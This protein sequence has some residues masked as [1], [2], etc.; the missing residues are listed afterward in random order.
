MNNFYYRNPTKII[1]G[2]GM[3][4][5]IANEIPKDAKVLILYGS[6]SIK[7]NGV[8]EQVTIALNEFEVV[9]FGGI[10]ANPTYEKCMDALD[11][12]HKEE[13]TYLLAV[14]GGSVIDAAKFLALSFYVKTSDKP[15][16][17]MRDNSKAPTEALPLG[18]ILTLSAT[19]SEMNNGFVISRE[20]TKEKLTCGSFYIY[21]QFSVL[22][23]ET[24]YFL[25]K[26][27]LRN[28]LVDIFIHVVEQYVTTDNNTPLQD[29]QAEA[30]LS[31]VLEISDDVMS[32]QNDYNSRAS[33]MW[34]ATQAL[35]GLIN[36]GVIMDWSTHDIGHKLTAQYGLAHAETIGIILRGVWENQ[37]QNKLGKLAQFGERV[38]GFTGSEEERAQ[39]AIEA[40]ENF[41]NKIGMD[42]HFSNYDIDGEAAAELIASLYMN[43]DTTNLGESSELSSNVIRSIVASRK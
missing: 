18:A 4:A 1:F 42:T 8:Y 39:K 35:N 37:F 34:C 29:R 7:K 16:D 38:W 32:L 25:S 10:P 40:T 28:G 23:P 43:D 22:D 21:P 26:R 36:R 33:M 27:Q 31:T 30:I 13:V 20:E 9:E 5:N 12:M 3:I 6:G 17:M 14:G 19:G 11:F 15:W 41:F 2:K 24:T